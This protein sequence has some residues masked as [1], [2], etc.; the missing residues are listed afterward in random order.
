MNDGYSA[1][2]QFNNNY[3]VFHGVI[4]EIVSRDGVPPWFQEFSKALNTFI[5]EVG[6]TKKRLEDQFSQLQGDLAIQKAIT[7]GLDNDRTR[8]QLKVD[9]LEADLED[10]RQYSRRTNVLIH[11]CEEKPKEDTEQVV[12]D[13]LDKLQLPIS[14]YEI[15]RTHRLGRKVEGRA[16]PIIVR[17]VSY[18]QKKMT[19]DAKKGLK[20]T[21]ILI[22]ES[23]T[24]ERYALYKYCEETYGRENVWTLDGRIYC[25]TGNQD[26][27]GRSE[28]I[29][30]TRIEDLRDVT[31]TGKV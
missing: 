4:E 31:F 12:L 19:Y 25:A 16:R 29:V 27:S 10:Q 20:G 22:T 23:L 6:G 18:R 7:D 17:F 14:R 21:R 3:E 8:L 15:G 30:V 2:N 9:Q 11:G 24:K 26:S 13:V 5:N 1:L 28:K